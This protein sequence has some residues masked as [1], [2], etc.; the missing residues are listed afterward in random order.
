[1]K[2]TIESTSWYVKNLFKPGTSKTGDLPKDVISFL[3]HDNPLL[4]ELKTRYA[5]NKHSPHSFWGS[6]EN[7][8]NLLKFR[9]EGDYVSQTYFRENNIRRYELSFAYVETLDELGLLNILGEDELFGAKTWECIPGKVVSRDLLDSILEIS[10]LQRIL[11]FGFKDRL[12][13]LDIGAGYGRFAHRFNTAYSN[14][15]VRCVDPIATSTFIS[16]FYL[17]FR[18]CPRTEVIPFD[19]LSSLQ[20]SPYDLAANIHSW[21]E[22]TKQFITFWLDRI[23]DLNVPYLFI[24]PHNENLETNESNGTHLT[25]DDE[26]ERHNYKLVIRQH[27]FHRSKLVQKAGIYPTEYRLYK[28]ES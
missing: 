8:V 2:S 16:E 28:L 12:R 15:S 17:K 11:G 14:S 24:I 23:R 3:S 27:K 9:G 20:D 1:M 18:R 4:K 7:R 21:S 5:Q 19:Q 22:C 10:F 26:L 6:W 13:V 25:Y